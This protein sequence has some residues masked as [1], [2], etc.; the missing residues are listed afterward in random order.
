MFNRSKFH[1]MRQI[2][3]YTHVLQMAGILILQWILVAVS[4][5]IGNSRKKVELY[6]SLIY[7]AVA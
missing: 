2:M 7:T 4:A 3:I 1:R 6:F 5:I